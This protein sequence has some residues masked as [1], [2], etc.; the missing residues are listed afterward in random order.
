MF[1]VVLQHFDSEYDCSNITYLYV[2]FQNI[3]RKFCKRIVSI[4]GNICFAHYNC[5]FLDKQFSYY[6]LFNNLYSSRSFLVSIQRKNN[7]PIHRFSYYYRL[8]LVV[9]VFLYFIFTFF[10]LTNFLK[11][12]TYIVYP[13]MTGIYCH[14]YLL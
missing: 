2:L 13:K 8:L 3:R 14:D 5:E 4:F 7:L 10:K 9:P 1:P 11:L 6:Y 12:N